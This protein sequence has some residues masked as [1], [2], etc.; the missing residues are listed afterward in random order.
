MST[1]PAAGRPRITAADIKNAVDKEFERLDAIRTGE[2]TRAAEEKQRRDEDAL[3]YQRLVETQIGMSEDRTT[4]EEMVRERYGPAPGNEDAYYEKIGR[5]YG[6]RLTFRTTTPPE[7]LEDQI[8]A[9]VEGEKARHAVNFA[10]ARATMIDAIRDAMKGAELT[11]ATF[12]N[13][14]AVPPDPVQVVAELRR[15]TGR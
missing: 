15:A 6:D 11:N 13:L 12:T 8:A 3:I 4:S 2:A 10:A 9:Y 7:D 1:P 14:S 5:L